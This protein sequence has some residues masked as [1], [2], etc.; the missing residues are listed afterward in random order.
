MV[1]EKATE[2]KKKPSHPARWLGFR[3]NR[4]MV[5]TP[6]VSFYMYCRYSREFYMEAVKKATRRFERVVRDDIG[7]AG[8][9]WVDGGRK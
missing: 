8:I 7:L 1:V 6:E 3:R 9:V 2:A 5:A 4:V